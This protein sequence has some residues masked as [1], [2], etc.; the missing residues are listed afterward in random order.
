MYIQSQSKLNK[1]KI[2]KIILISNT[3]TI[4]LKEKDC[5]ASKYFVE[6]RDLFIFSIYNICLD[7]K[8]HLVLGR[9]IKLFFAT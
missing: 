2:H 3:I 9:D 7:K 8:L 5:C 1:L 6:N 4:K